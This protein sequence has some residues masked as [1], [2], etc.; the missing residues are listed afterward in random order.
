M[1]AKQPFEGVVSAFGGK[2]DTTTLDIAHNY[3]TARSKHTVQMV[4]AALKSLGLQFDPH[5]AGCCNRDLLAKNGTDHRR[6][7]A[8]AF[9]PLKND[10]RFPLKA[11]KNW[12]VFQKFCESG[13]N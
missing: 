1:S 3:S 2:P 10:Q 8:I 13:F 7:I 9:N 5:G 11:G 6:K 12:I 4:M